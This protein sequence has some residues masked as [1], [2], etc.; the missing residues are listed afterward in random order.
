MALADAEQTPRPAPL[1]VT[2]T[3]QTNTVR[4]GGTAAALA[5]AVMAVVEQ[6]RPLISALDGLPLWAAAA[7]VAAAAVAV[8]FFMRKRQ[9][10]EP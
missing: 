8:L 2:E 9:G 3:L 10:E 4:M 7:V 1:T 5:T 6:V